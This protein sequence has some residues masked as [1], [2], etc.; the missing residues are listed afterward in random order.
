MQ[1]ITVE[2]HTVDTP[3][4]SDAA[5]TVN[6]ADIPEAA[7][8]AEPDMAAVEMTPAEEA[9]PPDIPQEEIHALQRDF[10]DFDPTRELAEN[11]RFAALLAGGSKLTAEEAYYL[12]HRREILRDA[13]LRAEREA[14]EKLTNALLSGSRRPEE[15]GLRDR[16]PTPTAID[17]RRAPK[18]AREDL[19]RRIREAA[20]RGERVYPMS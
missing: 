11:P 13:V 20:A 14:A 5:D 2:S 9:P 6:T 19:K 18:S 12:T 17:Y 3:D 4:A 15:A 1:E 8:A 10:P 7:S 16:T